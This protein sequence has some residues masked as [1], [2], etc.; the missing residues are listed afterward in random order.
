MGAYSSMDSAIEELS[1]AMGFAAYQEL[2]ETHDDVQ[3]LSRQMEETK[4]SAEARP[5]FSTY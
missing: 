2:R 5:L 1:K 3:N 4:A